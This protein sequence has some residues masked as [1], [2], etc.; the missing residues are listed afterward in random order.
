[1]ADSLW[2]PS[3]EDVLAIH[4]DIVS[5]YPE[6][7]SGVANRGDVEFALNYIEE[8]NFDTAPE[9]IHE[10]AFPII[11]ESGN[12]HV[13]LQSEQ[14]KKDG[15]DGYHQVEKV[16]EWFDYDLYY[17][18]CTINYRLIEQLF[19]SLQQNLHG[20]ED[21]ETIEITL[22]EYD[23]EEIFEGHEWRVTEK[24]KYPVGDKAYELG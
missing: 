6:T 11:C 7:H 4:D 3:V 20:P 16:S 2:Y 5:E 18:L 15:Q 8:G 22:F 12:T 19:Q 1:M 13:Y 17:Q 24:Q 9:S 14:V 21:G 23:L 10:K